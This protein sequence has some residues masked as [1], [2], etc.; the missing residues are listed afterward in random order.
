MSVYHAK[1]C[2]E[3]SAVAEAAAI[4]LVRFYPGVSVERSPAITLSSDERDEGELERVWKAALLNELLH[5]DSSAQ[6]RASIAEL[7]A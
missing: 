2:E 7:V 3:Q 5:N 6:R 1:F 4:W